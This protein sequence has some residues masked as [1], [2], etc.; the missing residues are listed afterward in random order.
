MHLSSGAACGTEAV[1]RDGAERSQVHEQTN[2]FV[3]GQQ[4]YHTFRIPS[5]VVTKKGTVLAFCEG[6]R[7][8]RSDSGDI[9]LVLKRSLDGG[10]TW[11]PMQTVA[12]D[13]LNT[14]GNPCPVVDRDTGT[15]WLLM[16]RNLGEDHEG[17]IKDGTSKGSRE[18]WVLESD[19]DGVTWSKPV[20]ITKTTKAADWTWYA[21]G[22]GCG[23]QLRTGRL[24]IPCDHALADSKLFRSHVIYSDDYGRSWKLGGVIG[25]HV[26]ECQV[27]E[28]TDG[29][30]LMNMRNYATDADKKRVH[31]RTV[32]TSADGGLTWSK[33]KPDPALI[34]PVCQAAFLRYTAPPASDKNRL[35][36]SNPASTQ[37]IKM[38]VRLSYDE[39]KT[40]PVAKELHAGPSAYS[41]LAVLP[42]MSIACLYE[43]GE[44]HAYETI[45]FAR[46]TLEWLTDAK[47]SPK[48][49]SAVARPSE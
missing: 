2:L 6:R 15:I 17:K 37:R 32:A 18:C 5:L 41:A 48:R 38:T 22:P 42:D 16:T 9:D 24:L 12:D 36:F 47:N 26:N 25:D 1:A 13:G 3:S 33:P 44:K 35:L 49:R 28:L 4:G 43:R 10:K 23:I 31:H 45:T 14:M 46:F 29:T 40:W 30:L 11:Q 21:T 27:V 7:S 8:S 19:D 34:E 20:E 39:G